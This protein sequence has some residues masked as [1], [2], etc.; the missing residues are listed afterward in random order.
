MCRVKNHG[1]SFSYLEAST[2]VTVGSIDFKVFELTS[3]NWTVA[4]DYCTKHNM[5][6]VSLENITQVS[7][8]LNFTYSEFYWFGREKKHQAANECMARYN[9]SETQIPCKQ[10]GGFICQLGRN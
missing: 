1:L 4:S 3:V 10:R 9:C 8:M 6:L 5:S 2:D 7:N